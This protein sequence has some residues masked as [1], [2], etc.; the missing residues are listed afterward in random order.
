MLFRSTRTFLT[1][2]ILDVTFIP[3][4]AAIVT[5]HGPAAREEMSIP[6]SVGRALDR[7]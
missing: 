1:S 6:A 3:D 5:V 4:G 2:E 7:P